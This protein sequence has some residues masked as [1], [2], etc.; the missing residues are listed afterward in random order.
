MKTR[1]GTIKIAVIA[2]ALA[3]TSCHSSPGTANGLI[4]YLAI[5]NSENTVFTIGIDIFSRDLNNLK[6]NIVNEIMTNDGRIDHDTV[7]NIN[8]NRLAVT[9]PRRNIAGFMERIKT[10]GIVV[11]ET[12]RSWLLHNDASIS[13]MI[14][15]TR[16]LLERNEALLLTADT[17]SD[18][19]MLQREIHHL[20]MQL[21]S[22]E[23]RTDETENVTVEITIFR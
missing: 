8:T 9:I 21:D 1:N 23:R 6:N 5:Q 16:D 20:Q 2:L 3:I 11:N 12:M 15:L 4:D 22:W 13:S 18:K 14:G 10:F 19:I 7:E 17:I